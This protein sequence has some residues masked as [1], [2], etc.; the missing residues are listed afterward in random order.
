MDPIHKEAGTSP[1]LQ[2]F[3]NRQICVNSQFPA[4]IAAAAILMGVLMSVSST[5]LE[6]ASVIVLWKIGSFAESIREALSDTGVG[7]VRKCT[8]GGEPLGR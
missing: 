7:G 2:S 6:N 5:Q 4:S 3:L 8:V 1:R